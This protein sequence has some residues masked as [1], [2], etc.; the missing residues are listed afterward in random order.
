LKE[1][2]VKY[3]VGTKRI[4]HVANVSTATVDRVVNGRSGVRPETA[5][6]VLDAVATL[7]GELAAKVTDAPDLKDYRFG[8]VVQAGAGFNSRL[9][10]TLSEVDK[11]LGE[12]ACHVKILD[13]FTSDL[14][15]GAFVDR[16]MRAAETTDGL[17]LVAQETAA[18]RDAVNELSST[19]FPVVCITTDLPTSKRLGCVAMDQ[20]R[21]GRA[22]GRLIGGMAGHGAGE[23]LLIVSGSFRCQQ[24]REIGFREVLRQTYPHLTVSEHLQS[25]DSDES[26]RESIGAL[27][28][29]GRWPVAVYNT[30]GG[31][32]GVVAAL[33]AAQNGRP[34]PTYICHD[35]SP[36]VRRLLLDGKIEAVIDY[37]A[38]DAVARAIKH[39]ITFRQPGSFDVDFSPLPIRIRLADTV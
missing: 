9:R 38:D 27:L 6:R 34:W 39:L 13:D 28:G 7:N 11:D 10:D 22:A 32:E 23:V 1:V 37:D 30:S 24:E 29:A 14:D 15:P 19:G 5:R 20:Y 18:I 35:L 25:R 21:A 12:H 3:R 16:I 4:A 8:M 33:E 36:A 17:I 31:N 26:A 2:K